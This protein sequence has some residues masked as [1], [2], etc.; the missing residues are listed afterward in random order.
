[1]L[2]N[3]FPDSTSSSCLKLYK[4]KLYVKLLFIFIN[5]NMIIVI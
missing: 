1:M 4:I 2:K 5:N 3:L